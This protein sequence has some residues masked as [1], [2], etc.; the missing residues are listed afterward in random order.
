MLNSV[1]VDAATA[2]LVMRSKS[3][4]VVARLKERKLGYT[5]ISR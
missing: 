1:V 4:M 3:L 2:E 5:Y